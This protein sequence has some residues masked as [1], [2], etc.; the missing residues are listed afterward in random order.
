MIISSLALYICWF[1]LFDALTFDNWATI[2]IWAFIHFLSIWSTN[3]FGYDLNISSIKFNGDVIYM[4]CTWFNM[5]WLWCSLG[6]SVM[7]FLN[8]LNHHIGISYHTSNTIL[9]YIYNSVS[10]SSVECDQILK[11]IEITIIIWYKN[12]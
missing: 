4:S 6:I 5:K 8:R 11:F 9:S 7:L 3:R 10:Y 1:Y 12:I 2:W